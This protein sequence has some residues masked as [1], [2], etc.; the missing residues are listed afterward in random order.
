MGTE[1]RIML[2][3][4]D[5]A[6]ADGAFRAAFQRLSELDSV[7]SDYRAN[8]EVSTLAR[9]PAGAD[10]P[11]S[12]DLATVMAVALGVSRRSEGA[13]DVTAGALT[14]LWRDAR[15]RGTIPSQRAVCSAQRAVGW[16]HVTLDTAQ[17][18]I[19]FA[20]DSMRLDF[21]GIAKGF[22]ADEA[23]RV[24]QDRGITR[25]LVV[26]GGDIVVAD[27]P[28]TEDGWLVSV[29][30]ADTA[31]TLANGAI[32]SSGDAE[33]FLEVAAIRYSHVID[34]RT[35]G[36]LT[37]AGGVSVRARRGIDADALSTAASVLDSIR[38]LALVR[39]AGAEMVSWR[40][41]GAPA[42]GCSTR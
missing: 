26:F 35:G 29:E 24:L 3:A 9:V 1:A 6:A 8:S 11:V 28:P 14:R 21:G 36:A 42:G 5:S 7:L 2:Y 22:A 18:T 39:D 37:G 38:A 20:I 41:A 12:A 17:L 4:R 31:V 40:R 13:F 15:R 33:Q 23:L 30:G 16:R 34:P 32:S 25:A 27:P 19:R 10:V